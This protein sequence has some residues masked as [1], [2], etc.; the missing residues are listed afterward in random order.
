MSVVERIEEQQVVE[1]KVK[2][3]RAIAAS[4][5]GKKKR[6]SIFTMS[7]SG[8]EKRKS[9]ESGTPSANQTPFDKA[10]DSA[11]NSFISTS[12]YN[13][14]FKT[15]SLS[16]PNRPTTEQS[17]LSPSRLDLQ[18]SEEE[19]YTKKQESIRAFKQILIDLSDKSL[20][21]LFNAVCILRFLVSS[22]VKSRDLCVGCDFLERYAK[23]SWCRSL[24]RRYTKSASDVIQAI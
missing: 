1:S 17:T 19:K 5:S 4:T 16:E 21:S 24:S 6:L 23:L 20:L 13:S 22:L 14:E 9:I 7:F 10:S 18:L 15:L 11:S 3:S 12:D 2:E 8:D